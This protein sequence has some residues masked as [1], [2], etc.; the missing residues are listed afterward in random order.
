MA[1]VVFTD[2]LQRHMTLPPA[3]VKART[4][5]QALNLVFKKYPGA[6]NYVLD[7][8]GV[9]RYHMVIFVDGKQIKD[10]ARLRDKLQ[11]DSQVYVMQALSGG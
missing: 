6:R 7:E 5:G 10:R 3:R 1:T 11:P 4:V 8:H 9:V 2:N